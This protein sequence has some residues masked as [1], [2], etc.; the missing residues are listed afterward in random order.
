[1]V[2]P[3][4]EFA[5]R[6]PARGLIATTIV[7]VL[8]LGFVSLFDFPTLAGWISYWMLCGIPML[9]VIAV[10][11]QSALPQIAADRSQPLKGVLLSLLIMPVAA[12]VGIAYFHTIGG[13]VGPPTPMLMMC[14]IVSVAITFCA[15]IMWGG[16]PFTLI[17]NRILGG[18]LM[19]AFCYVVNALL[20]WIFFNFEFMQDAPQYV[21]ALDPHG[22]FN[23]WH[24]LAFFVTALAIMFLV[25]NLELWPLTKS[26]RLMAQPILGIAWTGLSL[27]LGG[28]A[29]HVGVTVL[30]ADP[31]V[32]MTR[33]PVAF[34][35]GSIIVFNMLQNSL[36]AR[37]SQPLKGFLTNLA[38]VLI[39]SSLCGIYAALSPI[40][41]GP[42]ASG[43]P[44]YELEVWLATALLSVTFPF[45]AIHA[46]LFQMWPL[47]GK[48]A[49]QNVTQI[50][51]P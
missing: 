17:A 18:L 22:L 12:T 42:L 6:Q 8:S 28:V 21:A 43:P 48:P 51:S 2:S 9:L 37:F 3:N 13:G 41:T 44:A 27:V 4:K 1:M 26:A 23:A 35:F 11:W 19:L 38:A 31:V 49:T 47:A 14:T 25:L 30:G 16:W 10:S 20:F 34:I 32:F 45:L 46:D 15:S 40:L 24:A 36:F 33:G 5:M 7:I 29:Y 39:G 50:K